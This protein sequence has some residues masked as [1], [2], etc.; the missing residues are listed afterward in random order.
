MKKATYWVDAKTR[1]LFILAY[2]ETDSQYGW[3]CRK[4]FITG[5]TQEGKTEIEIEY[6]EDCPE[7]L[8]R[9]GEMYREILTIKKNLL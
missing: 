3:Q 2:Y 7:F 5:K 8:I 4:K 6:K 1:Y 9:L